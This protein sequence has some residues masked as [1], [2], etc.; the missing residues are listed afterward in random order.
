[1]RKAIEDEKIAEQ[2]AHRG[3]QG[4]PVEEACWESLVA[5]RKRRTGRLS[6]E[7][8]RIEIDVTARS[9]EKKC[10]G[11]RQQ[12]SEG[13]AEGANQLSEAEAVAAREPWNT[14]RRDGWTQLT[15]LVMTL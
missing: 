12:A 11:S 2:A 8:A 6:L 1:M 4:E 5:I 9:W 3:A 10:R 13:A 14:R 7:C 15:T